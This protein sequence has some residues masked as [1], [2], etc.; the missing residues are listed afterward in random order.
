M[1]EQSR[2][3]EFLFPRVTPRFLLRAAAVAL[4]TYLLFGHVLIPMI[5]RGHSMDPTYRDGGFTFCFTGAYLFGGPK[6]GD[7]VAVRLA[8]RKVMLLKRVVALEG[9]EVAFRAGVLQV[10]GR[11]VEEPYVKSP[12]DWEL[13]PR[14]VEKGC[15]YLVGDNRGMAAEQHDFGQTPVARIVGR[16]LW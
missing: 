1:T 13:E 12:C 2:L 9:E 5:V 7:V 15:V 10:D 11:A 16:P 8:G 3:Q 4:G 14:R 6:R